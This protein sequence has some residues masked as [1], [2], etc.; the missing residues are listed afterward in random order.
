MRHARFFKRTL[1]LVL[2]LA[3]LL[4]LCACGQTGGSSSAPGAS[5]AAAPT[6]AVTPP[7]AQ[8]E[9]PT[10]PATSVPPVSAN[11]ADNIQRM[12]DFIAAYEPP[13]EEISSDDLFAEFLQNPGDFVKALSAVRESGGQM[14]QSLFSVQSGVARLKTD[15]DPAYD[16]VTA[17]L[18]SLAETG[19]AAEKQMAA[20]IENGAEYFYAGGPG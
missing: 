11:A 5:A 16:G 15:A 7:P 20:S 19:S 3:L 13:R 9:S 12:M 10:E 1:I 4:T 17:A 6:S 18:A 2:P 14:E 8:A